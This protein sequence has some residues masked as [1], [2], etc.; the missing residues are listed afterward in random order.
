VTTLRVELPPPLLQLQHG[1]PTPAE[2]RAPIASSLTHAARACADLLYTTTGRRTMNSESAALLRSRERQVEKH[3]GLEAFRR[4]AQQHY[5]L[6]T[7]LRVRDLGADPAG[8][9]VP[10]HRST[11]T[12]QP[13]A[14]EPQLADPAGAVQPPVQRRDK[15]GG[16][17]RQEPGAQA[18]QAPLA[19]L[20]RCDHAGGVIFTGP[21]ITAAAATPAPQPR[22]AAATKP[23]C[24]RQA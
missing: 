15:P 20:W 1:D 9:A 12:R 7:V 6:K 8:A 16:H 11:P 13:P 3:G 2:L 19:T 14:G 21:A 4:H 18:A 10:R 23:A 24:Q 5:R 22:L 17:R